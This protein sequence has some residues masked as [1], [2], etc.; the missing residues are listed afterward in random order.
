MWLVEISQS[1]YHLRVNG[2]M[3]PPFGLPQAVRF[4]ASL[5]LLQAG[6]TFCFVEVEVL[7]R[8]D[9]LETQ[10]VLNFAQLSSWVWDEPL[11][12]DQM[13]LSPGEPGQPALKVLGV[14]ANP[15]WA[16][17]SVDLTYGEDRDTKVLYEVSLL[18]LSLS[19]QITSSNSY[20]WNITP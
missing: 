7:V 2:G 18:L 16:P 5:W 3:C 1:L 20:L 19:T 8:D 15:K 11:P 9:P 4:T 13:D 6:K 14:Q 10:K 12:T 17:L